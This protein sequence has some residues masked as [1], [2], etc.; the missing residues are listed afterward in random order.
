M[1]AAIR[2]QLVSKRFLI[3]H[4]RSGSFQE[5][6][7]NLVQGQNG[8]EEFWAL[9]EVD[10]TVG[11]GET[12]AIVGPNGSG[13][14]TILKLISRILE[15]TSGQ[16]QVDGRVV[17]M[18]ELGAGFHPDLSGRE[19]IFLWGSIMGLSERTMHQ[20]LDSIV[21]FA[22]LEQFIDTP[23]KHYSLGMYMRLGFATAVHVDADVFLMDEV[24]AVGDQAFQEKCL[25]IWDE[26]QRQGKTLVLVS[27]DLG[28]VQR[29]SQRA[30][31][32]DHGRVVAYGPTP[33]VVA[34]YSA[35]VAR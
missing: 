12:F 2:F 7:I 19:N 16:V 29:F 9:K 15:P 5:L 21:Q 23:V 17:A 27:H 8:K 4:T 22:E 31:L 32:L 1:T 10:F 34:D 11:Q 35:S 26:L 3:Q 30:L 14:S 6:L 24:L 18:I 28:Q 33:D 25:L 20:R 13:K